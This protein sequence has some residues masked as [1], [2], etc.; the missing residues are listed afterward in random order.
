MQV[1]DRA[2]RRLRRALD[3][4]PMLQRVVYLLCAMDGVDHAG[5]AFRL[6][7]S[8]LAVETYLADALVQIGTAM[9]DGEDSP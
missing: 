8:T 4:L 3:R 6:G 9:Q 7:I 1:D 2:K 5:V